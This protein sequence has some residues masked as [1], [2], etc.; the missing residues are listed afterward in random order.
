ME[1]SYTYQK[2]VLEYFD[3]EGGQVKITYIH[4]CTTTDKISVY[5]YQ[6]PNQY[7]IRSE[8]NSAY[9]TGIYPDIHYCH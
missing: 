5:I 2:G 8:Y 6:F 1:L 9:M 7:E 3:M 4:E